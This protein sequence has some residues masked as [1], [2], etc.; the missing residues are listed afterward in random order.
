MY[1]VIAGYKKTIQYGTGLSFIKR[2]ET[3]NLCK[4]MAKIQG[5]KETQ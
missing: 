4:D 3:L 1:K 2:A 5:K